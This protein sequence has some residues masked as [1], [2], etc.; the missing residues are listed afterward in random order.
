MTESCTT[1]KSPAMR[2]LIGITLTAGLLLGIGAEAAT[3]TVNST[4]DAVDAAPGDGVCATAG[5]VCT[6]RAAIQ[7]SNAFAGTDTVAFNIAGAGPHTIQPTSALPS[8]SES[9]IIDG[10]TEPDF[11]GTPIIELNGLLAGIG[12]NGLVISSSGGNSTIRGLAIQS[13]VQNGILLQGGNNLIAGNYIGLDADGTTLAGN[14]TSNT[15][16]QGG[17]RVESAANTIGGTTAADRNVISGNIFSGIVLAGAG[18]SGN[19]VLGNYIGLDASGVLDRGNTQEGIEIDL[20]NNN[21]IGGTIAGARNVISGNDSDGIEIDGA[22]FTIVQ[23]NY[24]GTDFTG[25]LTIGNGRDGIDLND[26]GVDGATGTLIGGAGANEG[27]LIRGNGIYGIQVRGA[28]VINNSILGN[29]IYGNVQLGIDLNDDGITVNDAFDA[30]SGPNDLLNFP[31]ITSATASAGTVSVGFDLDVPT[32]DYRIEFFTNPSG[33]DPSGNGEGE[34]FAS[35]VNITHTGSGVESFSHSFAGSAGDILTAN[36]TLCTTGTCSGFLST[37][38]F[39]TAFTVTPPV[40]FSARWPLDEISGVIAADVDAGNDGTYRNGVLLNQTAACTDTGNAVHFD[41]VDDFVEVPHSPDYLMDEGTVAFWAN[42]DAIGT[43]QG[44]FSKD[45]TGFDTGGHLTVLILPTGVVQVRLQST[46]GDNFVNSAPIAAGTW[47]HVAFSWGPAGMA[48]YI[49]GAAPVT[50]AYT[51]GLGVTSGG[52]GNFEP[53]SFGANSW[54]SDDLLVTPTIDHFAGYLDDV[55][56]NNPALTLAEIQTLAGCTPA[57]PAVTSAMA[58][59]SPNDVTTSS[60][61]NAFSYD[62]AATI[63]ALDTGVDRVAITVPG[64]FGVPTV[65]DV[66]VG[67][68]SVAFTDNTVIRAISVDLTV[69]VTTSDRITV[70][71]TADAP[72]IQDL[73]GVNFLSTVDDSGTA[74]A[75][76]A[77]TEGNGDGDAGDLNIWTVTTTDAGPSVC[78]V[79]PTGTYIEAE[80]FTGTIQDTAF[81]TVESTQAG[82]NGSGY[83]R[84][85]GGGTGGA[86]AHEGKIYNIEFTTT[87]VYNVWMRGYAT[88]GSTDSLFVG[89]NGTSVGALN[90]GGTYDVWVWTNSIQVGGNQIT[91]PAAGF[92]EFNAW[93]RENNHLVDGFYL[94]QGAETPTGGIPPGVPTLDPTACPFVD[95]VVTKSVMTLEDP[96][97]ATTDPKAIPGAIERY[98]VEVTNTGSGPADADTVFITDSLPA[99]MALRIIDYDGT[100]PGPVAFVNGSPAS[101]LSYTFTSLGSGTDDI[102]FSSDGGT[103][104]TYTPVDSGDGTDPAVTDTRINPKGIFANNTGGGDPSFQLLFKAVIQ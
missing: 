77:T 15:G 46:T 94:T 84:S 48:L 42:A 31:V 37:S 21:I 27:N 71:F 104:W 70:L 6:L 43:Q 92:H 3:F 17:I 63:G 36:T 8:I 103:T 10:T 26:N 76:Q 38:E 100:N 102:E 99:F 11:T 12:T 65:I 18:A 20:A 91:V 74:I 89:L 83:L 101:G 80:N 97:N 40:T 52:P 51:G 86:P 19:Q 59:I 2:I 58:E 24:I 90:E 64:S 49:D 87:G 61:A 96:V 25:T 67:G 53:I 98:L 78:Q 22:D 23:G 39:S 79:D 28:S 57:G 66:Q 50:N 62:I 60:T 35:S 95:L 55:R 13:F 34:A 45:S 88:S 75:A 68:V 32:G 93:I 54:V 81:F 69:K 44:L 73:T 85:N 14:N 16:I 33:A 29:Q 1:Y 9:V 30:D 82:F 4:A 72:T 47:V 5:A 56:I 7:E 41:G